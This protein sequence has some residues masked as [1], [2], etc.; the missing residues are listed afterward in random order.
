MRQTLLTIVLFLASLAPHARADAM[1]T[2]SKTEARNLFLTAGFPLEGT[3]IT[4]RCG[5]RANPGLTFADL[6][7][8]GAPEVAFVDAGPCYPGGHW[9]SV[10]RRTPAG[11]WLPVFEA[12]GTAQPVAHRTNGWYDLKYTY[13]GAS[14]ILQYNGRAYAAAKQAHSAVSKP[15]TPPPAPSDAVVPGRRD[16]L[17][18]DKPTS[19]QDAAV[20]R[21]LEGDFADAQ[22]VEHHA[23]GYTVGEADLNDDGRPDLLIHLADSLWCG[24]S[25]CSGDV[26]MATASGYSTKAIDLPNFDSTIHILPATHGGMHDLRFDGAHYVF[27]WNGRSYH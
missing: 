26:L 25:G 27:S 8:D 20:H 1:P 10:L 13:R 22:K 14:L 4:N 2:L 19:E 6:N 5:K 23:L 11:I 16:V 24:S 7:G 9:I 21:A 15:A 18:A 12:P 17:P 3:Q